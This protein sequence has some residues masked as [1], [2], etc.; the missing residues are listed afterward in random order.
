M[1]DI[2]EGALQYEVKI[3][4]QRFIFELNYFSCD[5][6]NL[7]LQNMELGYMEVKDCP[8]CITEKILKSAD[9]KLHQNGKFNK[10][11]V[12][13]TCLWLMFNKTAAQMLLL[14][15]L[16][17]LIIGNHVPSDDESWQCYLLMVKIVNY[18]FSPSV[19]EDHAAYLQALI[20]D[21]HSQFLQVY[22]GESVIPKMHNMVHM[23]RLMIE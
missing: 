1:H 13:A 7:K 16:L 23:P 21:H 6:I 22:P 11:C 2:L 17:P 12:I 10:N 5:F 9:N 3:M 4:L 19:S 14:M 8:T 18:L 15:K 20:S